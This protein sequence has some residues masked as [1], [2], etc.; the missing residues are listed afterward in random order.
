MIYPNNDIRNIFKIAH[1]T[2]DSKEIH[3]IINNLGIF[4]YDEEKD[5]V[6]EDESHY[7]CYR[8]SFFN[9]IGF[10]LVKSNITKVQEEYLHLLLKATNFVELNSNMRRSYMGK[11]T[12]SKTKFKGPG[13]IM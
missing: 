2:E 7:N 4:N 10:I 3:W 6:E 13:W 11:M 8:C 1:K 12:V 5:Y 9:L